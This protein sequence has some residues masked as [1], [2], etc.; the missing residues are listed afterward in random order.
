M[1]EKSTVEGEV[2]KEGVGSVAEGV[3]SA[4]GDDPD[5]ITPIDTGERE[6][7][8]TMESAGKGGGEVGRWPF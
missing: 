8:G 5:E 1:G 2:T 7:L 4:E 6:E 3:F